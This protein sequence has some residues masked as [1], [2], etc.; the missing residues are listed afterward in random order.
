M[1]ERPLVTIEMFKPKTEDRSVEA[2]RGLS[3]LLDCLSNRGRLRLFL[4][5][6][7]N[8]RELTPQ[9]SEDIDR[10]IFESIRNN[11][12]FPDHSDREIQEFYFQQQIHALAA[13]RYYGEIV[14]PLAQ[15]VEPKD[16]IS[17]ISSR[18]SA[19]FRLLSLPPESIDPTLAY[20]AQRHMLISCIAGMANVRTRNAE[21]REVLYKMHNVFNREL[22]IGPE[23]AGTRVELGS[24]HDNATKCCGW[25]SRWP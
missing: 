16:E 9:E 23:G 20:E 25:F 7:A 3:R 19:L 5:I 6:R 12:D 21:L 1:S 11:Y 4:G 13:I 15:Y 22:F 18:P 14:P 8:N 17:L 2:N 24:M 10:G